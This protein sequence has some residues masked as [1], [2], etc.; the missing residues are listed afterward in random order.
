M[1]I[2]Q[3]PIIFGMTTRKVFNLKELNVKQGTEVSK[4][5]ISCGGKVHHKALW[6]KLFIVKMELYLEQK[7]Q[8]YRKQM[9]VQTIT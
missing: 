1:I 8:H 6:L 2:Q 5:K 4:I 7:D 9:L 3:S